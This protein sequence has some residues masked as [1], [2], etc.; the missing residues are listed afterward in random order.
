MIS[1][2]LSSGRLK[3]CSVADSRTVVSGM[4]NV[5]AVL[6][7]FLMNSGKNLNPFNFFT[8]ININEVYTW[9]QQG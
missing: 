2:C 4:E 9:F 3:K 1:R 6:A 5:C 7:S 8:C